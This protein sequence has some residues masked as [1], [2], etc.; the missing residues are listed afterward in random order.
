M[1]L[2]EDQRSLARLREALHEAV[3]EVLDSLERP[4]RSR[5]GPRRRRSTPP[6]GP[7]GAAER[8]AARRLLQEAGL[9]RPNKSSQR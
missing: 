2:S 3:D 9:V 5:A 4:R 8:S 1:L 7:P 6:V